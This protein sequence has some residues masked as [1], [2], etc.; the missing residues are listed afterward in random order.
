M[1]DK[2]EWI[3]LPNEKW[4]TS[5]IQNDNVYIINKSIRSIR[6]IVENIG[7]PF[8]IEISIEDIND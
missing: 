8:P 7:D 5:T 3:L 6:L 2:N 4:G 1:I